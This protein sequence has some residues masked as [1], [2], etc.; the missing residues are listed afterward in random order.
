MNFFEQNIFKLR[1]IIS[2]LDS[3]VSD[4][5]AYTSLATEIEK[6]CYA[7][8]KAVDEYEQQVKSEE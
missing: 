5:G 1:H 3:C 2:E 6:A 4:I 7:L 8:N